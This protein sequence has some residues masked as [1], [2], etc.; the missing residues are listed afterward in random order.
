MELEFLGEYIRQLVDKRWTINMFFLNLGMEN[1][2][3]YAYVKTPVLQKVGES[4]R[5]KLSKNLQV[6]KYMLHCRKTFKRCILSTKATVA[7]LRDNVDKWSQVTN[8]KRSNA[9][10]YKPRLSR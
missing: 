5:N 4:D 2:T 3:Q 9:S 7:A 10:K 8:L 6:N 1:P